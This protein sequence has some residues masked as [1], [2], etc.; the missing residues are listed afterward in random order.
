MKSKHLGR[1]GRSMDSGPKDAAGS[2]MALPKSSMLP[3]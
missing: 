1:D 2:H 3:A